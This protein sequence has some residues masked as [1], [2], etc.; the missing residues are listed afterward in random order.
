MYEAR[1][2]GIVSA[3]TIIR[4]QAGF[5]HVVCLGIS[6]KY[7]AVPRQDSI[8]PYRAH[9]VLSGHCNTY[10]HTKHQTMLIAMQQTR[11]A[12]V[13]PTFACV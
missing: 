3:Y 4:V 6:N 10:V 11:D 1:Y 13:V 7:V 12:R 2:W 8:L 9:A 5:I